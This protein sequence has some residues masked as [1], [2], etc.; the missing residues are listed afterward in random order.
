MSILENEKTEE[1]DMVTY[2]TSL[3]RM[4]TREE[5]G[6]RIPIIL[7]E[8][9]EY[10]MSVDELIIWGSLHWC[11]LDKEAIEKEYS[12]RKTKNRIFNDVSFEQT[13]YQGNTSAENPR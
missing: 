4:I 2:Y 12:R 6:I 3:G 9:T 11:F 5:N 10:Q 13:L 8:D 1:F 7:V